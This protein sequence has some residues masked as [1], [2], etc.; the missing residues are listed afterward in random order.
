MDLSNI[1]DVSLRYEIL[2]MLAKHEDVW[3]PGHLG[4]ITATEHRI[5][6]APG[7]K[8]IRQA[9]YR[10]GHRG[11]DVQAGEIAKMLEAGVIEPATSEWASPVVLVPKKDGSLRFCIDYR[12]LNAKRKDGR[13]CVPTSS[14]G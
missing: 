3:H 11:R 5:E 12:R 14:D 2:S 13:R 4:E 1:D 7:T 10:Q 6:L 9:P 8:P